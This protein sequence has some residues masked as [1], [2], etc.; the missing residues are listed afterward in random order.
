[1]QADYALNSV[2]EQRK[3]N[4]KSCSQLEHQAGASRDPVFHRLVQG[5]CGFWCK[6]QVKKSLCKICTT[7]TQVGAVAREKGQIQAS[8][9]ERGATSVAHQR[10]RSGAA[11]EPVLVVSQEE[12]V[13]VVWL[14]LRSCSKVYKQPDVL[15]RRSLWWDEYG[16]VMNREC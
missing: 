14:L 1:M 8:R 11:E 3:I 2:W 12:T 10:L 6:N 13:A 7:K 9:C 15:R 5:F 4:M 16:L